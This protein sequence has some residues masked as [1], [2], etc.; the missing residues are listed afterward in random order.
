MASFRCQPKCRESAPVPAGAFAFYDTIAAAM[1]T[2]L[3]ICLSLCAF[4]LIAALPYQLEKMSERQLL[5][6]GVPCVLTLLACVLA[7]LVDIK[8][9][10]GKIRDLLA[11]ANDA[12]SAIAHQRYSRANDIGKY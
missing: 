11:E 7:V 3:K 2:W 10:L 8:N 6:V 4:A 12:D 1:P 5:Q 9:A